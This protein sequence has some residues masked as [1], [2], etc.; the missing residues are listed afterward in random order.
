MMATPSVSLQNKNIQGG[1]LLRNQFLIIHTNE[2][3]NVHINVFFLHFSVP[4]F[5]ARLRHAL[6]RHEAHLPHQDAA[7]GSRGQELCVERLAHAYWR[8]REQE[9]GH[10]GQLPKTVYVYIVVY[11]CSVCFT[12]ASGLVEVTNTLTNISHIKDVKSINSVL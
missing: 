5:R 12:K 9:C 10:A 6:E 8:Y 2:N 7:S 1:V 11:G 4:E 3:S